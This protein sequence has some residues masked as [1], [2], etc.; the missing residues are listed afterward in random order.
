M[1]DKLWTCDS[2]GTDNVIKNFEHLPIGMYIG[3]TGCSIGQSIGL[4]PDKIRISRALDRE[5]ILRIVDALDSF[6]QFVETHAKEQETADRISRTVA[7][8]ILFLPTFEN[9]NEKET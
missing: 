4:T 8:I 5:K 2:C 6:V 3:C 1:S 7:E 9:K